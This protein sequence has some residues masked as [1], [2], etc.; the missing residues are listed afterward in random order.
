[1]VFV[2]ILELV[3]RTPARRAVI[4]AA[5][6]LFVALVIGFGVP[7]CPSA[8]IFGIPC[9]G[10]GLTRATLAALRGDFSGALH[11]HPL[12]FV[13]TPLFAYLAAR[14]GYVYVRGGAVQT[15]GERSFWLSRTTT[16]GSVAV[17]ALVLGVW[18]ARFLGAFG[19]PVPVTRLSDLRSHS[20][21][22]SSTSTR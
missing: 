10:C 7:V 18:I 21:S 11:F 19:G 2:A 12:V 22:A 6:G 16:L 13:L 3:D 4:L 15:L 17:V 5:I 14:A 8:T 20:T 1:L 9:P